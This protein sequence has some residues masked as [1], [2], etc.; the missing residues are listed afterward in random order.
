MRRIL[1]VDCKAELSKIVVCTP[2]LKKVRTR[3]L[4][5]LGEGG[6]K[7]GLFDLTCFC[8]MNPPTPA[9]PPPLKKKEDEQQ[10]AGYLQIR[11]IFWGLLLLHRK[12]Y[13]NC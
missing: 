3:L 2:P 12:F 9:E 7:G 11:R 1:K 6:I 8:I 10:E 13:L 4:V 5:P